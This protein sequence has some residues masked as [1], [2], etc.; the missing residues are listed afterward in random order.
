MRE[1]GGQMERVQKLFPGISKVEINTNF[2]T[3]QHQM[4]YYF[5]SKTKIKANLPQF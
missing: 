3:I 2:T 1:G 4:S 5:D